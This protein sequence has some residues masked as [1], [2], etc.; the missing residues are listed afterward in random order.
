M[1]SN[2]STTSTTK[3]W[4]SR[5][6]ES[7]TPWWPWARRPRSAMQSRI[8]RPVLVLLHE[9]RG[10]MMG[11]HPPSLLGVHEEV[12]RHHLAT[13]HETRAVVLGGEHVLLTGHHGDITTD[14]DVGLG[15][16][17]LDV[18]DVGHDERPGPHDLRAT[19]QQGPARVD[20]HQV[21]CLV[22]LCP[23]AAHQIDVTVLDGAVELCVGLGH[24]FHDFL[25]GLH[26]PPRPAETARP[27]SSWAP[28]SDQA[29]AT[30]TA[31]ALGRTSWTR[32]AQAPRWAAKVVTAVVAE[33]QSRNDRSPVSVSLNKRLRKRLRE[34]ATSTGRSSSWKRSR[35]WSNAQ[36]CA[37]SGR[38]AKPNPGSRT[39]WSG[40]TPALI[41]ASIRS[42]SPSRTSWTT[43]EH[44]GRL[45]M[46]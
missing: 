37:F 6:S 45:C 39:I 18:G 21:R 9:H 36:L 10:G 30:R 31:P 44:P 14:P 25:P 28:P 4:P 40:V 22:F 16:Y 26:R 2:R 23:D 46:S 41:M 34:P 24:T 43:S 1:V 11:P 17:V 19:T 38:L 7:N 29:A 42:R 8:H 35:S 33:S 27:G 12:R 3:S 32:T 20:A 15:Q 5:R 13:R